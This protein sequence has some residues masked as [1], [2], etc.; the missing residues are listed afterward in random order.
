[1]NRLI[2]SVL[3]GL[4]SCVLLADAASVTAVEIDSVI[5]EEVLLSLHPDD[6]K[7]SVDYLKS[8]GASDRDIAESVSRSLRRDC[9]CPKEDTGSFRSNAAIHWLETLG[10]QNQLSNLVYVAQIATNEYASAAVR[11]Y[12]RKIEEKGRFIDVAESLLNRPDMDQLKSTVWD[13]LMIEAKG[14][15][16]VRVLAIA[17]RHLRDGFVNLFYADAVL[18]EW[19]PGYAK[20]PLRAKILKAAIDDPASRR[21]FPT[22]HDLLLKRVDKGGQ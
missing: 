10:D 12:Y 2:L 1:M 13:H 20:G 6:A 4:C 21:L 3:I 7:A 17:S 15:R 8:R 22:L 9:N 14:P 5:D 11:A 18:A 19:Q 16:R